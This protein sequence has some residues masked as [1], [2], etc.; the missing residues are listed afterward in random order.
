MIINLNT[1]GGFVARE[2]AHWFHRTGIYSYE[3]AAGKESWIM[4][5]N[6]EWSSYSSHM[7][8]VVLCKPGQK[9]S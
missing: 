5:Q 9:I 7:T 1:E 6:G 3:D 2:I 8:F 4:Y